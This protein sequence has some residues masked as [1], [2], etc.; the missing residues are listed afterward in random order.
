[1][2]EPRIKGHIDL[3]RIEDVVETPRL[4]VSGWVFGESSPVSR[5]EIALDER[6]AGQASIARPRA[7][8]AAHLGNPS[9][10]ISGFECRIDL[11]RFGSLRDELTLRVSAVLLNGERAD[12]PPQRVKLGPGA[13]PR[14]RASGRIRLLCFARS[15]DRGGSQLRLR[16][17]L[18]HLSKDGGIETTVVARSDGPLRC[19]LERVGVEVRIETVSLD[20]FE[21]YESTLE[22]FSTWANGRFDIVLGFTLTSFVAIDLANALKLPSLWR[23]GECETLATVTE[24]T[25]S[26]LD[27]RLEGRAESAFSAASTVIFNSA[28]TLGY[29]RTLGYFGRFAVL[30]SGTD[31]AGAADYRA[32]HTRESCRVRLAIEADRRVLLYAATLWPI[33]QQLLLVQ[34]MS[35]VVADFPQ[36]LCVLVGQDVPGYADAVLRLTEQLG[37]ND[38]VR[39]VPFR[40]GDDL[41]EL[42]CAA[43]AAVSASERESL[44]ASFVEA[45]AFGLPVL[46]TRAGGSPEIIEDG[47]TGWLCDPNDLGSLVDGLRRVGAASS[48]ELRTMGEE[49]NRRVGLLHD[50]RVALPRM[51]ELIRETV[52]GGRPDWLELR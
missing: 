35:H 36:L 30:P 9:A 28:V 42:T 1:M 50:Q 7:D 38:F 25:G 18:E 24:W 39:V 10:G 41:R 47:V 31:V 23:I 49:A 20:D 11:R 12:L 17:L 43:D 19:D 40:E 15:L 13:L 3:P 27:P 52:N 51:A 44:S 21:G 26:R 16:E 33:K 34:A 2:S 4:V 32:R 14:T 48:E 6:P 29:F 45:M 37:L 22:K 8:V 5:V 46:A